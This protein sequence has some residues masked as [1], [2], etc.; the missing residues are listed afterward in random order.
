VSRY[1]IMRH[2]LRYLES[3]VA[4]VD[5]ISREE[6]LKGE[7]TR[8]HVGGYLDRYFYA[9]EMLD[10]SRCGVMPSAPVLGSIGVS[11]SY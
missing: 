8:R 1:M 6:T 5:K 7:S 3:Y 4:Y 11:R 2:A 9:A 10:I